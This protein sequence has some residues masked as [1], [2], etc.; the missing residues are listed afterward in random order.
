MLQ[1]MRRLLRLLDPGLPSTVW[2]LQLGVFINFLGNGMV[3][4]FLVI[5]L[6][7]GR[8]LPL[9]LAGSAVALGGITAVTSGLVAG[10][11]SDRL[12]P[13]NILVAAMIS[14]ASA[15]LL[16]TQVT[17]PWQAFAVGLMVGF[18][19]GCYGPSSQSLIASLVAA[20]K[21]QAA[22]AQ[23]RVTSVVGLGAGGAIG[24]F[25]A[26]AGLSG[27]LHLLVLDAV[28]FLSFAALMLVLSS[29]RTATP[30]ASH[31]G[32]GAVTRDRAFLWLVAVNVAMVAAGIA[33]MLVLL[34]A[35]AK[36]QT[37]VGEAAIGAIYAVN[38]LTIVAAQLPLTRLTAALPRMLILRGAAGLWI[39][40]WLVCLAAG[41][42]LRASAAIVMIAMAVVV[43]ALGE[44]L[45][46]SVMLPTAIALAPAELRGRYLGA[47]G[48]AWQSG[49]LIG[50]SAGSAILGVAPLA[51]PVTC[52]AACVA[53]AFGTRLVD[54]N[55]AP[56]LRRG[57]LAVA[58][59]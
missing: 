32:Y 19:T 52:A 29:P 1:S 13:R 7:F 38:T 51:L 5:Y 26:S 8:G 42:S 39:L 41:A 47:M 58:P 37:H 45:Y 21:R 30:V 27:Y 46:S 57:A 43:Y 53:A 25:I 33:P 54:R 9:G 55:L 56:A 36:I 10:S 24:G 40:S 28:T 12:G 35:F 14:N 48:L 50:P 31:G 6:H 59:P 4:P 16:Y 22:F 34:P 23:N 18:G 17:V 2:L 15:Y 49:F 44:C 3:A 11:M 20:E